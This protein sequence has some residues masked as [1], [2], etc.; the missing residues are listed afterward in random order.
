MSDG[1]QRCPWALGSTLE[2]EYHDREWGVPTHDD[3]RLF[4]ML[5]LE[6]AQAGL[7]WRTILYRRAGYRKAFDDFDVN[8]IAQYSG[9]DVERLLQ[10]AGIVRNRLKIEAAVRNARCF[11][12]VQQECGSFAAYL[13]RFTGGESRLNH[14]TSMREIPVHTPESDALSKN[15]KRRGFKF[16]GTTI[17]Y[18]YM[19]AIGLVNDHLVDCFRYAEIERLARVTD[20]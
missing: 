16:V 19:Q 6:G 14:R 10:D 11:L 1:K 7:S 3:R 13:W 9:Q 8:K 2:T 18:A 12:Q 5:L 17:C 20:A 4:E 15:L